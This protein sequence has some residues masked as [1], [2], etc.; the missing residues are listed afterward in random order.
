LSIGIRQRMNENPRL[1]AGMIGVLVLICVAVVVLEVRA[2]RHTIATHMP[3]S[4]F[5]VDDGQTF[6]VASGDNV[7]PFEYHGQTA[8][9]AYLFQCNG[10]RF[11]GYLERY[12][13]AAHKQM[14]EGKDTPATQIYGRELKRPGDRDWVKS[15]DLK[16][17]GKVTDVQCPD[18]SGTPEPI[19]P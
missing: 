6:F 10:K 16:A 8:V 18:G 3:D 9:H 2:G 12:T 15:G 1:T 17:A 11:V 4:Y 7:P 14:V 5:T 19:E 13:P